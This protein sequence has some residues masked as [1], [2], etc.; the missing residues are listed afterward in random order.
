MRKKYKFQNAYG[1]YEEVLK[2]PEVDFVYISLPN[3]LHFEWT[4]KAM[5]HGKDVLCEKPI[6]D[7]AAEVEKLIECSRRTGRVFMEAFHWKIHPAAH[8]FREILES[9]EYGRILKTHAL[10]TATPALPPGD[11]RWQ[12]DLGGGSLMDMTYVLSFTRFAIGADTPEEVLYARARAS[13]EDPRVDEAMDAALRFTDK[14]GKDV[15][16]TIYT[17][18]K[19][20]W[21]LG[22]LPRVW[23]L[24][25]IN[26][27]TENAEVFF[28]NA[29]MPHIYHYV[30]VK[31][32]RTGK[33]TRKTAYKGGMYWGDRGEVWWS[34][35]RYQLEAFVDKLRGRKPAYWV[36]NED[37]VQ[38]MKTIEDVYKSSGLPLR[39]GK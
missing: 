17:D 12:Y 28:Y 30:E 27:E 6:A 21:Y 3:Q 23:E 33:T 8:L 5:E 13:S 15:Y 38:Q 36:T 26:V 19:R 1:S 34:T 39:P 18:M 29:M 37:S 9:G 11:I 10:M 2:D 35:Y 14:K 25:S 32:K 20:A 16:G 31:D 22:L 7:T 4:F 24:P